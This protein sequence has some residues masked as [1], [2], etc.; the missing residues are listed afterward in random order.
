[1]KGEINIGG[2]KI[3]VWV[4][5]AGILGALGLFI[6]TRFTG[7]GKSEQEVEGDLDA[8]NLSDQFQKALDAQSN[9][10]IASNSAI[11]KQ[12]DTLTAANSKTNTDL[13]TALTKAIGD[14]TTYI[15]SKLTGGSPTGGGSTT[16]P[17]GSPIT[18]NPAVGPIVNNTGGRTPGPDNRW[19]AIP[20]T[21]PAGV[22]LQQISSTAVLAKTPLGD[23]LVTGSPTGA[24]YHG[25][26]PQSQAGLAVGQMP[27]VIKQAYAAAIHALD[28]GFIGTYL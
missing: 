22:S 18:Y 21:L 20:Q 17:G 11:Q 9:A 12:I 1:M 19:L 10:L 3:P 2:R 4:I 28:P 5:A 27:D 14:M 26:F 13:T 24:G 25:T 16:T 15:N 8:A 7:G 23:I 6:L